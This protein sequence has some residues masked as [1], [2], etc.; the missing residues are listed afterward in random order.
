MTD[1]KNVIDEADVVIITAGAGMGVDSGLADFRGDKGMWKAYP[2]LSDKHIGFADIANQ[3]AFLKVPELAWSFYGHRYDLYK[4][5]TPHIGFNALLE[6]VKNKDDYFVVTSNVDGHFQKAGFDDDKVYEVH[7][8]INKVQCIDCGNLWE[9]PNKTKFDVDPK[10][11]KM[12]S[13]LPK[14]SCGSTSTRPNI[15]L[16]NDVGFDNKETYEQAVRFND[17]MHKYDKGDTKIVILEFG[18][19]NAIPTIRKMGE[20]IQKEVDGVTLVR[21]NPND[22][23]GPDGTISVAKG[24]IDAIAEDIVPKY[25][26][27]MFFI[28]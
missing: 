25:V 18:A 9:L 14:C 2:S 7:G 4:N 5:T 23:D 13:K 15:M 6:M 3:E 19:G 27:D 28:N 10:T 22:S 11:L 17:F 26:S 1:I 8:R 16:F 24:A 21:I 20:F 12:N